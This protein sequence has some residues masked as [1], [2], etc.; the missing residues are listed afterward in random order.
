MAKST[1]SGPV[2]SISGFITAG[3][4][5]VVSLT[6][7]TSLTVDAH[8]GKILTC[9]DADGKFTLPSIVTTSPSDPTDPNQANNL[10]ASF[11][12]FVETAATDLD[13]KTDGTD[14]F[15]GGLYIG[16]NNSTG[17]TFIS[18]ASNDVITLNG[19][20]KGGIAGSIIKVTAA[21]SAK[22]AVEGIV[23]GS[24]TLVTMFADA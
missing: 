8:A 11:F 13:I 14:K 2:K 4:T 6:A 1:F 21:A 23:L 5:S 10:G 22:Y 15:V 9:N 7:D 24:G 16:V 18:G 20:T 12:F 3:S 17:K 19:S